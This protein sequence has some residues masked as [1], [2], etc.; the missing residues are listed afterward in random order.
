MYISKVIEN[1]C[2]RKN[3]NISV[4]NNIIHN[5]KK[6]VEIAKMSIN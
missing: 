3:L 6:K 1:I 5:I 2:P 4:H